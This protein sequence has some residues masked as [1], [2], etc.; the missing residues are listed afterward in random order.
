LNIFLKSQNG[1]IDT[2]IPGAPRNI[3]AGCVQ[4]LAVRAFRNQMNQ[5]V[6]F[7]EAWE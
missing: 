6:V 7:I 5:I 3:S 2:R 1:K 4:K